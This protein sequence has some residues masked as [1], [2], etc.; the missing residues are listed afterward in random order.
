M[1]D[2]VDSKAQMFVPASVFDF[3]RND[4][5]DVILSEVDWYLLRLALVL[6]LEELAP[7]GWV[8]QD[9]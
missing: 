1:A 3:G 9:A 5:T 2:Q 4:A 7:V 8:Q 6:D